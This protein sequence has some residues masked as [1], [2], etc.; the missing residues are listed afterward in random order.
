M[1]LTKIKTL[2]TYNKNTRWF[3]KDIWRKTAEPGVTQVRSAVLPAATK[4]PV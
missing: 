4:S 2:G 1:F 3:R